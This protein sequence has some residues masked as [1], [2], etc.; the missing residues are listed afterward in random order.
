MTGF[1]PV[2]S[3]LACKDYHRPERAYLLSSFCIRRFP[4]SIVTMKFISSRLSVRFYSIIQHTPYSIW[5]LFWAQPNDTQYDIR[6]TRQNRNS[7][8]PPGWAPAHPQAG[9]KTNKSAL[10]RG[11]HFVFLK[12]A[13]PASADKIIPGHITKSKKNSESRWL[14]H[15]QVASH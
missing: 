14:I 10:I 6:N 13:R 2:F 3:G 15:K 7:R 12:V 1:Y 4:V 11:C 8:L 5:H 9:V